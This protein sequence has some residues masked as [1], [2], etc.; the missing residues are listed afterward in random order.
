MSDSQTSANA[1]PVAAGD[2]IVQS[3]N[4]MQY[5]VLLPANYDP[6]IKYPTVL[7]LHQLDMGDWPAGLLQEVNPWFN[8]TT[9]RT[10]HP[11]IV[12]MPLLDQTAD[13]SGGTIN[14]GGVGTADSAGEVNAIAA[15]QQ[16]MA[17]YSSDPTRV[18]VTGNSMG[19]IGTEDMI[20][21]YNAYTG[22]EGKIFAAGLS[23]AGADYG[24]GYPQ[25]SGSVVAALKNVPFWAIHGGQ[26]T[27]VPL[28][29]DQNLYAAE[30]ASGGDMIYTQDN[31]LGHDVWDTYYPQTGAG[32]PLGW[33]FSQRNGGAPPPPSSPPSPNDTVVKAGS[34]AAITDA[35]GNAWTINAAAQ[36]AVNGTADTT[37]GNVIEL[38]YVGG[39]VWQE[40]A[41]HLWWGTKGPAAGWSLGGGTSSS[42]LP[43]PTVIPP[44]QASVTVSQSHMAL[45]ARGGSHMVFISGSNDAVNL[46]GGTDTISDTG[47][48][49]TYVVP[50]A[51][52]GYDNFTT[53]ILNIGDTL[54]LR[55]VLAA[56]NWNGAA[57]TLSNYLT[58]T[59]NTQGMVLSVA[60]TSGGAPVGIASIAG[61]TTAKLSTLLVHAL[62]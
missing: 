36:V 48:G 10:D 58:V 60:A 4:G 25:P 12:V 5:E 57:A 33:L 7:Y 16:V 38:A 27:T 59:D 54:D 47:H 50:P 24:Q 2:W 23:L 3:I 8:N 32:S 45:V 13:T 34:A 37:T 42:P 35:A 43:P 6:T 20:I 46:S 26:D 40:N 14:F 62:T 30:Q 61:A 39:A 21:K 44:N 9:F 1:Q 56:T 17:Q 15:L 11:S 41:S 55:S 53:N 29:W 52:R 51:G 31:S 28:T 19:G 49:N 18:Y 22:T